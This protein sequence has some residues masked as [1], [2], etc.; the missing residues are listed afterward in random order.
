MLFYLQDKDPE[1]RSNIHEDGLM[2]QNIFNIPPDEV[3][4]TCN[5][6]YYGNVPPQMEWRKVGDDRIIENSSTSTSTYISTNRITYTLKL[7]GDISL[8]NSS[9]VCQTTMSAQHQYKCTSEKLKVLCKLSTQT[10]LTICSYLRNFYRRRFSFKKMFIDAFV[11]C[12]NHCRPTLLIVVWPHP[13]ESLLQ[14]GQG[15]HDL[16]QAM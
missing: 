8:E 15:G 4:L 16:N 10:C 12:A 14:I 3:H 5:V 2:G 13:V 6:T 9:Y 1:C 7:K 11:I